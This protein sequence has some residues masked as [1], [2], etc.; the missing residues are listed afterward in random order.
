MPVLFFAVGS[1]KVMGGFRVVMTS[2][3]TVF[4]VDCTG[5]GEKGVEPPDVLVAGPKWQGEQALSSSCGAE[6]SDWDLSA[7]MMAF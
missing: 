5:A 1:G 6:G 2:D 3:V 7:A 4:E